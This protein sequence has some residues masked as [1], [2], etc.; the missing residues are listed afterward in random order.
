VAKK[1]KRRGSRRKRRDFVRRSKE[2]FTVEASSPGVPM[3]IKGEVEFTCP[4]CQGKVIVSDSGSG[5]VLHTLPPCQK[6]LDEDALM[7]LRNA[8]MKV[9][10]P[11][12][13]DEEFP[14]GGSKDDGRRN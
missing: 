7:F 14:I 2:I 4:F 12:P 3:E 5:A 13:G 6:Y 9:V 1:Q 11:M 10:G 8:R